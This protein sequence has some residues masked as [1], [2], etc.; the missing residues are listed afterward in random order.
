MRELDRLTIQRYGVPSLTL[1]ERAGEGVVS[2]LLER[3][4]RIARGGVLVVAG[5]GNNGGDGL[6]VAR[7]L[8][9]K[10]DPV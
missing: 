8:K 1:M 10:T 7:R 4:G 3:F 2:A 6:V 9:K 5:K